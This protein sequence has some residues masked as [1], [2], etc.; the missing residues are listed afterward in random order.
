M[1]S[2]KLSFG[3]DTDG[4]PVGMA[5]GKG[6]RVERDNEDREEERRDSQQGKEEAP[7]LVLPE[8][9]SCKNTPILNRSFDQSK[10]NTS[11]CSIGKWLRKKH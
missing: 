6:V 2:V 10:K 9:L 8:L 5:E 7:A 4:N 3:L 1:D 11:I